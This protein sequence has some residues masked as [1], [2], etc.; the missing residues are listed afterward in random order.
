MKNWKLRYEEE[1]ER[2]IEEINAFNASQPCVTRLMTEDE[3]KQVFQP[4]KESC[5]RLNAERIL[6][7]SID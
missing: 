7:A 5:H 6:N 1:V 2:R 4:P 3:I